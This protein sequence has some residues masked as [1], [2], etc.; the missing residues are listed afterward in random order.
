MAI[1]ILLNL[2][3][4]ENNGQDKPLDRFIINHYELIDTVDYTTILLFDEI[5]WIRAV[6]P[7]VDDATGQVYQRASM[8]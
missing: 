6:C 7:C 3:I 1:Q 5:K 8:T 4:K 2:V